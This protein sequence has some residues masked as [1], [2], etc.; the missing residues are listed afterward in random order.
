MS[1]ISSQMLVP[2][3]SSAPGAASTNPYGPVTPVSNIPTVPGAQGSV[4][5][6]IQQ[7]YLGAGSPT[8]NAIV[9]GAANAAQSAGS[10]TPTTTAG[11]GAFT[12]APPAPVTQTNPALA[13]GI[14]QFSADVPYFTAE[15]NAQN[16]QQY[17][18][19]QAALGAIGTGYNNALSAVGG[20]GQSE[21]QQLQL[22]RQQQTGAA[23]NQMANAGLTG[24]TVDNTAQNAANQTFNLGATSLAEQIG[25][26]YAGL[27]SQGGT[28]LANELN[29]TTFTNDNSFLLQG[30]AAQSNMYIAQQAQLTQKSIAT[31]AGQTAL[32]VAGIG[33]FAQ[34]AGAAGKGAAGG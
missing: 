29:N 32:E 27:F 14:N 8:G 2:P 33:A 12:I 5:G 1:Q 28:A 17:E 16:K 3:N 19:Q 18:Q 21:L 15:Q 7:G 9:A 25:A 31:Q 24:S 10:V 13:G 23:E 22:Q 30:M 34:V 20:A 6:T 26:E 11:A 4:G